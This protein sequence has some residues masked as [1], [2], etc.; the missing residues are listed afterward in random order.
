[1]RYRFIPRFSGRLLMAATA[2]LLATA[3]HAVPDAQFQEAAALFTQ[4]ASG[5]KASIDKAAEAFT[6]LLRTEP[7]NPV[8]M[9]YAGAST[10][11]LA[12]TTLLPWKKISY[13]EDGMAMID[14]ALALLTP[15][16]NDVLQH[17]TPGALEVRFVAAN[18]FLA[19]PG[20]MNRGARGAKL[21][22]EVLDSPLLAQAPLGF[23]GAV[24]LRAAK[25][26]QADKR[27]DEARKYLG[28]VISRNAPQADAARA[29]L[30][31]LTP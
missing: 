19:V 16:H 18:T 27:P 20:F 8:L 11:R 4:A 21:L 24:W 7:G 29:Q 14:K 17:G 26:A 25:L 3:A 15:A 5:D 13:A 31:E 10:A 2:V 28:E 9:A 30:K 22:A 6:A 1:M 12:G 23:Q